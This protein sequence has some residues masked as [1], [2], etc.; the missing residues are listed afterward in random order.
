VDRLDSAGG[1]VDGLAP[2]GVLDGFAPRSVV[3]GFAPR[4]VV[5]GFASRGVMDR[6][7][8]VGVV[9]GSG[10]AH[11]SRRALA[12]VVLPPARF[13]RRERGVTSAAD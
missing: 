9:D 8:P 1:V 7:A 12:L 4:S 3:D 10:G 2:G 5:D 13:L 11:A 6:R